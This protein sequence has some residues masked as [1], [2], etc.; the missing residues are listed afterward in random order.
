MDPNKRWF[1]TATLDDD[2][3]Y[4]VQSPALV[5]SADTLL[6]RIDDWRR[7]QGSALMG[8]DFPIGVPV[9][10][11]DAV[12]IK[13]FP[14]LLP[15]LGSGEWR[16]FYRVA[17]TRQD[18][19]LHRPFYPQRPGCTAQ[20]HLYEGLG[21]DGMDKLLRASDRAT[22][23]RRTACSIFWTLGGNQVGKGA[24]IGWRDVLG[25][26]ARERTL[27]MAIWPFAGQLV[28]LMSES[29]IVIAETYPAEFYGHLGITLPGSKRK[30]SVRQTVSPAFHA[31]L[32]RD[33]V[34][35]RVRFDPEAE[36][37][38]NSGFGQRPDGEDQFDGFAGLLG[39]LNV[40]LGC[41]KAGEPTMGSRR[42]AVEGWIL[43]Q[44]P[45]SAAERSQL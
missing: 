22:N 10:Y 20:A 2:G 31:W 15:K 19:S 26:A 6:R 4:N 8:F 40:V 21:F 43:G 3:I 33:G 41:R 34:R 30:Q 37:S 38:I 24:I 1:A 11:A 16:D 42:R 18:I 27:P 7:G 45:V 14:E 12:D 35:G 9:A 29:Q 44:Q 13:S 36:R 5:G 25:P 23:D 28:S 39:M 32:K 17:E